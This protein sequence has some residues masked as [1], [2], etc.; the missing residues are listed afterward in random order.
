ML[1]GICINWATVGRGVRA[2]STSGRR[3]RAEARLELVSRLLFLLGLFFPIA[4]ALG[5]N[6][7]RLV[8]RA[9]SSARE[10]PAAHECDSSFWYAPWDP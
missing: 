8:I 9:P 10:R 6:H 4:V 5:R 1:G 3:T 7:S 2:T